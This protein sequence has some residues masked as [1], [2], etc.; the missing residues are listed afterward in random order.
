[1]SNERLREFVEYCMR[2]NIKIVDYFKHAYLWES[3]FLNELISPPPVQ[4]IQWWR[5]IFR[6]LVAIDLRQKGLCLLASVLRL[7]MVNVCIHMVLN[8]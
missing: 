3:M 2:K 4:G 1:M 5:I 7:M 6:I 8:Y